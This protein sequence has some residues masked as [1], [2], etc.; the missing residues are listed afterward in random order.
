LYFCITA[1]LAFLALP[2]AFVSGFRERRISA[3]LLL[4]LTGLIANLLL[5]FNYSTAVNWRYFLAGIPALA[6]FSADFLM[7]K[8]S[9]RFHSANAAFVSCV[10][11]MLT[12]GILFVIYIRPVSQE[13]I[14]RRAMSKEYRYQLEHIP[15]DGIMISGSQTIAV[16]YWKA[17]G[18][19]DWKTIGTGGGW[20]GVALVPEI[21]N[22]LQT[23][24]RVFLD[25]DPRW[26]LPCGW[27][28][29]E[30]PAIVALEQD[31]AF[32]QVT[33]TIFELRARGDETA[34]AKPELSRLLPQNRP[35]DAKKCA[36]GRFTN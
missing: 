19:G 30:I 17:M 14:T 12:I 2:F 9:A 8:L 11:V 34:T 3:K 24:K 4:A 10:V 29:D 16:T 21:Q 27:Q 5:F 23:G 15:R 32:R 7:R 20:P 1:P 6:P 36:P 13:F 18:L 28:R 26:W 35:E 33:P 31:F 25:A 22:Y